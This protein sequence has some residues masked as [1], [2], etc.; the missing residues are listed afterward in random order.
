[1]KLSWLCEF[2]E[3][4][5]RITP[6]TESDRAELERFTGGFQ[7]EDFHGYIHTMNLST[8]AVYLADDGV[9]LEVKVEPTW[10]NYDD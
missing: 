7:S 10:W 4:A 1:M 8:H 3:G 2:R 9:S 5:L 6:E